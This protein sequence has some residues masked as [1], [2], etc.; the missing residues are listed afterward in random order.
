MQTVFKSFNLNEDS[1]CWNTSKY[2]ILHLN[3][4]EI[5]SYSFQNTIYLLQIIFQIKKHNAEIKQIALVLNR[6][7]SVWWKCALLKKNITFALYV[8]S[9]IQIG[10]LISVF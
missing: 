2:F 10:V 6:M 9:T 1:F 4:Q 7:K 3:T 8:T 5:D